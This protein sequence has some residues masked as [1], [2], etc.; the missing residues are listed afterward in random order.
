MKIT[1][2]IDRG[3]CDYFDPIA[4]AAL[5][6]DGVELA[7]KERE[8]FCHAVDVSPIA[9]LL[10]QYFFQEIKEWL[11]NE[12]DSWSGMKGSYNPYLGILTVETR[13]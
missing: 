4:M 10:Q 6:L 2:K 12:M 13:E 1:V 3:M 7:T 11:P 8:P 9:T 5:E